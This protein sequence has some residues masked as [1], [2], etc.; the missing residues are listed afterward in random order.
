VAGIARVWGSARTPQADSLA[1]EY[2]RAVPSDAATAAQDYVRPPALP[3][4]ASLGVGAVAVRKVMTSARP[5]RNAALVLGA[6]AAVPMTAFSLADRALGALVK[7]DAY[8]W[9]LDQHQKRFKQ[10]EERKAAAFATHQSASG[11][12][13]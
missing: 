6:V 10:Q 7:A 12:L 11:E 3:I 13:A 4:V 8:L 1:A 5:L 9:A 2:L